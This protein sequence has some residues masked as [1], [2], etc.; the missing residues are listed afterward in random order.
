MAGIFGALL[1]FSVALLNR[2]IAG[3]WL[4]PPAIFTSYWATLML[5]L[6]FCG[7]LFHPIGLESILI[8][9]IGGVS[10]S[11]GGLLTIVLR[12]G[13]RVPSLKNNE[14]T[15]KRIIA[16]ILKSSLIMLIAAFPFYLVLIKG[17]SERSGVSDFW[18]GVRY[19]TSVVNETD[20]FGA[21][22]YIMSFTTFMVLLALSQGDERRRWW[23]TAA[24]C[25]ISAGYLLATMSRT[26]I[27]NLIFASLGVISIR[28]GYVRVRSM[29]VGLG[30]ALTLFI[31]VGMMLGKM[32]DSS[33][34][35]N[36]QI[37][38]SIESI[39]V[40][41]VSGIVAFDRFVRGMVYLSPGCRTLRFFSLLANFLGADLTI[42]P[43]VME[44][45]ETPSLTNIYTIY[46]PYYSDFGI[47]GVAVIFFALGFF[48]SVTY[49]Y[50][51]FGHLPATILYGYTVSSIILSSANDTFFASLSVWIQVSSLGFAIE[52]FCQL[53]ATSTRP[54]S[55]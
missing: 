9:F 30:T 33:T 28:S 41:L 27:L 54:F 32:N 7:S 24:L 38:S 17:I 22:K 50:A 21:F 51:K 4:Y 23:R 20:E 37:A 16:H 2:R 47:V 6:A 14:N 45:T 12:I 53:L 48:I 13:N 52:W 10:L 42:P 8:I 18:V 49:S 3:S 36:D 31:I 19:Q 26:G 34:N 29:V 11:F 43:L 15:R 25:V 40:Y 55:S 39:A 46:L 1:L 35:S 44:Y 5:I